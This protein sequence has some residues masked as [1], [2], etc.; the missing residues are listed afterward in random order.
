MEVRASL[1]YLLDPLPLR[2][3]LHVGPRS[4]SSRAGSRF[5]VIACRLL[6]GAAVLLA[7]I[8]C[9]S[10]GDPLHGRV[11]EV[12]NPE[13]PPSEW[14]L[15]PLAD[16]DVLVVWQGQLLDNPVDDHLV[17]LRATYTKTR[18]DGG[19]SVAGWKQRPQWRWIYGVEAISF[20]YKAGYEPVL[21][22]GDRPQTVPGVHILRR[23]PAGTD[24]AF[25]EAAFGIAEFCPPATHE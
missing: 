16:V 17:C 8:A 1:Y 15:V 2:E 6:G 11:F 20:A 18:D 4:P 22:G 3:I 14:R 5:G 12:S 13:A 24:S 10:R 21:P 19:F 7:C 25:R 23:S 9:A